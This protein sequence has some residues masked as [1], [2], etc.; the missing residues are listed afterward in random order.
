MLPRMDHAAFISQAFEAIARAL[1]EVGVDA[2]LH[3]RPVVI[4][5]SVKR[6]CLAELR[7]LTTLIRRLIFLM[8][9]SMELAPLTPREGRNYFRDEEVAPAPRRRGLRITPASPGAFPDNLQSL[10]VQRPAGPVNA[11]PVI[12]RWWAMLNALKHHERRAKYLARTLQRWRARREPRPYVLTMA[13]SHRMPAAL[14]LIAG[15]LTVRLNAAL[16]GWED[17]G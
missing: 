13:G 12:A 7:R 10:P 6:R 14:G 4:S 11:A 15:A 9:L 5:K 8:A 17:T 2:N 16:Q 1:A 3:R